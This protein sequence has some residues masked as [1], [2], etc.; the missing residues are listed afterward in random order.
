MMVDRGRSGLRVY[1]TLAA[2]MAVGLGTRLIH[3]DQPIV[4]NYVGRQIPTAMVARNLDRGSGFLRPALDVAPFP[5]LFLVEPPLYASAVVAWKRLSGMR[6]EAS[7]RVVS[8]LGILLGAWGLFGLVERR[9]GARVGLAAVAIFL[10]FPVTIRYGRAFQPDALMLG[11]LIA[12]VDAW[13]R[14][15]AGGRWAWLV[16]GFVGLSTGL[17]LKVISAY[18]LIPLVFGVVRER[19]PWKL[20]LA[21]ATLIPAL[22]WYAHAAHLV[23]TGDGSRASA[24]NSAVWLRALL[25]SAL[26]TWNTLR[27][28]ARFLAV[29]AFTPIGPILAVAGLWKWPGEG[30]RLWRVWGLSALAT[31]LLLSAKLHHEYYWLALAPVVAVGS[32]RCLERLAEGGRVVLAICLGV[33]FLVNALVL[34]V[35]TYQTPAEWQDLAQAV[36]EL[37]KLPADALIVAPEAL[38]FE[39]DRKGCRLERSASAARRAAGEWGD[40]VEAARVDSPEALVA[41]YRRR[42]ATHFADGDFGAT[43]DPARLALQAAILN[44]YKILVR[45]P[46]GLL[47][48]DLRVA[49]GIDPSPPPRGDP[50]GN[51]SN[52]R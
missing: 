41:F 23:A 25:P 38:L 21:A 52:P 12:G 51:E 32:G 20:V 27:N 30:T 33:V 4:E 1:A 24:D 22:L 50:N 46:R 37:R 31:M 49:S 45:Q 47:L 26:F 15:E 5:N 19:R 13:D 10:V 35:S 42:G 14:F 28:L 16:L 9:E 39:A 36:S 17:A 2:L 6:L 3:L 40:P 18:V 8:A 11:C 48:A 34:A 7:G 43:S 44:R 29:R